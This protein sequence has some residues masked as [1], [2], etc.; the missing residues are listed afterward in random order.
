MLPSLS[1]LVEAVS[2]ELRISTATLAVR[3]ADTLPKPARERAWAAP[4]RLEAGLVTAA[5][6]EVSN[7]V[8]CHENGTTCVRR[9][10]SNG[11]QRLRRLW[12]IPG[13]PR[14][15]PPGKEGRQPDQ[16]EMPALVSVAG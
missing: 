13:T 12:P 8:G 6:D 5:I 11:A 16:R 1:A 3:R 4:A 9:D 7:S 15:R 14:G 10:S 2:R